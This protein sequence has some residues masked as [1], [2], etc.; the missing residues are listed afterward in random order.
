MIAHFYLMSE[1]FANNVIFSLDEIEE[2]IKR[3][4][5]DVSLILQHRESNKF[6]SN[7]EDLYPQIFY[8]TYTIQ[9]FICNSAELK[10]KG[11]DRD[12]INALNQIINISDHTTITTKE[13]REEMLSWI[14]E[15]ECHGILAFHEIDGVDDSI[16]VIYGI[17]GWYKFRRYFLSLYP[18]NGDFFI[19]ECGKYFPNLFFHQRNKT[20]ASYLLSDSCKK[21]VNYLTDLNDNYVLAKTTPYTRIETLRRFNSMCSFDRPA[22]DEGNSGSKKKSKIKD[23]DSFFFKDKN[24]DDK[25]VCCDLHLKI[26][27]DD[28]GKISND[29]RVYF[30]EGNLDIQNGK[31]LIGHIGYH[32]QS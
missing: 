27:K 6:Y 1:S 15:S 16:Q 22:S 3:L 20:T 5:E 9:D 32:L 2:K 17:D 8:S 7:T 14:N 18:G 11:V 29:R 19:D 21:L 24:G 23:R 28:I 30:N 13:V 31:I 4:A 25:Y 10:N 26:L 12:V